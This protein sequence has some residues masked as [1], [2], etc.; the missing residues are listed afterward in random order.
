VRDAFLVFGADG[1]DRESRASIVIAL[2]EVIGSRGRMR[3]RLHSIAF[4]KFEASTRAPC[5][6]P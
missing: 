4:G 3:V 6:E 1:L 5:N 2:S